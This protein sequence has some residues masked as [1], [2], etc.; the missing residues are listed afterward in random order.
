MS[1]REKIM[2]ATLLGGMPPYAWYFGSIASAMASGSD[3]VA[4]SMSGLISA[5]FIGMIIMIIVVTI[6][7]IAN[8]GQGGMRP[9]EREQSVES[10]GF[11]ISYHMLCSGVIL[12]IGATWV[13]WSA[14][15]AIH[16]LAFVF[17]LAEFT[18]VAVEIRGLR[19]GF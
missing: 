12:T 1:F 11:R 4:L 15:S 2:W 3:D 16:L 5:I 19:R 13:S 18:R 14:V 7:A 8:R 10:R 6:V 9:D 17:I